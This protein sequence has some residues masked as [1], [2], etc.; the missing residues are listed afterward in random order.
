MYL[1]SERDDLTRIKS[2]FRASALALTVLL[3]AACSSSPEPMLPPEASGKVAISLEDHWAL[4]KDDARLALS[5]DALPRPLI[6][7]RTADGVYHALDSHC[8]HQGCQVSPAQ[9][10][11]DLECPCHASSFSADGSV[12]KGPSPVPLIEYALEQRGDSLFVDLSR[13]TVRRSK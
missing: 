8:P 9:T 1:Q 11:D 3:L 5:V 12:Q 10:G 6:I 4:K 13:R 2:L 7:T